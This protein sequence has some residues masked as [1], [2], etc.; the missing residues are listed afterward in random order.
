MSPVPPVPKSMFFMYIVGESK[1]VNKFGGL[2]S[3]TG[4]CITF[5]TGGHANIF[6]GPKFNVKS[7]FG[8]CELQHGQNSIFWVHKSE[9]RKDRGI[10]IFTFR[11][12][13]SFSE[14]E[15]TSK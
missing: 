3:P 4:Y 1:K 12:Q 15:M 14:I 7:I 10:V 2:Q 5:N 8:V 9:K 11:I 13:W 6:L